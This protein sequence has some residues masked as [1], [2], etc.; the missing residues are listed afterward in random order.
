MTFILIPNGCKI[1]AD[2]KDFI[3]TSMLIG[4]S[5]YRLPYEQLY[6]TIV[7]K[8]VNKISY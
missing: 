7:K 1:T 5:V 4:Q 2:F 8:K 6:K 3:M